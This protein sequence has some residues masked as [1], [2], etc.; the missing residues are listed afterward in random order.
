[1][2]IERSPGV[3]NENPGSERL[4]GLQIMRKRIVA[5][6]SLAALL[7]ACGFAQSTTGSLLGTVTDSSNAAVPNVQIEV[8]NLTTGFVRTTTT[9][10]E[11]IFRFNS[12]EPAKYRSEE[13]RV[14]K[15]GRSR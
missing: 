10:P 6:L 8:K 2:Y 15:E 9:G 3:H 1:M 7:C 4:G 12:L 5:A 11:G 13:R 14:G